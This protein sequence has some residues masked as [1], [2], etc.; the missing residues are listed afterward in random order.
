MATT[1]VTL[2]TAWQQIGIGPVTGLNV[3]T[4]QTDLCRLWVDS[5]APAASEEG[6]VVNPVDFRNFDLEDAS[7]I[8][9]ARADKADVEIKV[10]S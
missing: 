7:E 3:S 4:G 1:S 9:Y 10:S 6:I 2:N 5:T 8:L